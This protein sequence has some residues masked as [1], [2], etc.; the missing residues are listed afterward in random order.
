MIGRILAGMAAL[1]ATAAPAQQRAAAIPPSSAAAPR[2][3]L[4]VGNSFTQGASS[5]VRNWGAGT[6]TDLNGAGYGGV[7]AL[8]KQFTLQAGLNYAVSL[9]SQG[10]KTLGFHYDQRRRLIDRAWDVVVLQEYSTLDPDRAGDPTNY[11]R[12]AGRLAG[13]MR[14]RN[15][16]VQ[17]WLMATWTRADQTYKP[18]GHW[19]G[20][21]VTRMAVD[22]RA[23]AD[24]AVAT[25]PGIAG[26]LPV[27]QAWNRAFAAGLADPNPYDGKAFGQVDLW[28]NDQYHASACGYYLEALVVFG[29]VT[30]IDPLTPGRNERAADELGISADQAAALQ[31]VAHDQLA[32][33]APTRLR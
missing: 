11:V 30:G 28:A 29:R 8:F 21:P 2:S 20:Q 3:I 10:G 16:A 18:G 33:E 17:T 19:F 13:L 27:G 1:I 4:F 22:L 9:E 12:D 15:P 26:V 25:T 24:R 23:A 14:A 7:P 32:A 5:P 6:I 31:Q